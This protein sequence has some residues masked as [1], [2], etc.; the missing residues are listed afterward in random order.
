MA[1]TGSWLAKPGLLRTLLG[2][3]RLAIRL[4]REPAVPVVTKLVPAV[5][6]L[7]LIWPIDF[8]PDLFPVLGQLDDLGV[9]IAALEL[10][11]HLSPDAP[12]SFHRAAVAAGRPYHPMPRESVIV[13]AEFRSE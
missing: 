3:A 2:Q 5:A 10:F 1:T 8:L 11:L 13:D 4:V 7:Y 9:M 6:G 12:A